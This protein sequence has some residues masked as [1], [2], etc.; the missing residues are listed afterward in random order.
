MFSQRWIQCEDPIPSRIDY[1]RFLCKLEIIYLD[2][3]IYNIHKFSYAPPLMTRGMLKKFF[4]QS[5]SKNGSERFKKCEIA[6]DKTN[7]IIQTPPSSFWPKFNRQD[8]LVT[9]PT[10]H[11]RALLKIREKNW[12]GDTF[13]NS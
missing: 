7:R 5:G 6:N 4:D 11:S 12:G 13:E 9:P 1:D 3:N 10:S 2:V 8:I